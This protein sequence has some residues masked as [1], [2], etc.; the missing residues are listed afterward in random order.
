MQCVTYLFLKPS[1]TKTLWLNQFAPMRSCGHFASCSH[2]LCLYSCNQEPETDQE[3]PEGSRAAGQRGVWGW[4]EI[5]RK[6]ENGV[7][8]QTQLLQD[9]LCLQVRGLHVPT[10]CPAASSPGTSSCYCVWLLSH[11]VKIHIYV[12]YQSGVYGIMV[13]SIYLWRLKP[14]L[15]VTTHLGISVTSQKS[16]MGNSHEVDVLVS[17][18]S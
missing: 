5:P 13:D 18:G 1:A 17:I 4:Q 3:V 14:E 6:G 11:N 9:G 12:T 2:H 8:V 16:K 10:H 7:H 15:G